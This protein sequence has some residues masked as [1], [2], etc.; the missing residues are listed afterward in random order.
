MEQFKAVVVRE[1]NGIVSHAVE[2]I[3]L[4]DL[5]LGNVTIKVAYSSVNYKDHLAVKAGGGVIRNYPMIPG[6]DL[7]GT[8]VSS[9][10]EKFYVGQKVLVTGF[11]V[12]MTHTGGFSEYVQ[13]PEQWIVPLPEGLSLRDAM[14]I[15]TAGFTAA[16]SID[17]LEKMG[18]NVTN[19]PE[20][21]VTG[22]SGGVGS[23]A[24]R[25][26]SKCGYTNVSAFSRK[27][28]EE[29]LIRSFGAKTVLYPED[30]IPEKARPLGKQRFHFVLDAV[31]GKVASALIPQIHY[32]GSI[33]M[34]GN[35]A[36]I[37]LETTVLP[38]IL[39]GINALGIDSVNYPIEGRLNIWQ[40]FAKE[41]H[42]MD[43][44]HVREVDLDGLEE[45]FSKMQQGTHV[46]R[47]IVK[48][49]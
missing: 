17:A 27:K 39:R 26:L 25:L 30:L 15:G 11:Q 49:S 22:A 29:Q 47:T 43:Q 4:N 5:S 14:V 36:G 38:F 20:I 35:A 12:G 3:T 1:E 16:I 13:I 24:I 18:M 34:C 45:I 10:S 19:Q 40:R 32:G 31:G 23:I 33:S 7:S 42:I 37:G 41:W 48:I 9:T 44:L 2:N 28:Q 46:G 8:V 21:L 6:I